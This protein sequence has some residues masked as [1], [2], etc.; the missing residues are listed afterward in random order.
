MVFPRPAKQPDDSTSILYGIYTSKHQ[1]IY[2]YIYYR[3]NIYIY[4][5]AIL[6]Y[7]EIYA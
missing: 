6:F 4:I 7:I 1:Y 3:I 5:Y 2:I